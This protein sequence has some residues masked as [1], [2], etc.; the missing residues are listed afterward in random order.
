MTA[1]VITTYVQKE[2]KNDF[3]Q[4]DVDVLITTTGD[5]YLSKF[6]VIDNVQCSGIGHN[7]F[8]SAIAGNKIT[9]TAT[10]NDRVHLRIVGKNS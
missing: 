1:A 9:I 10:A 6:A 8:V 7:A 2:L 4:E 5:W 3:W